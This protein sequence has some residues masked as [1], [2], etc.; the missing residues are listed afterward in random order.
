MSTDPIRVVVADDFPLMRAAL[1]EGWRRDP[2]IDVVGQASDGAEAMALV[3]SERPDVLVSDLD[4][5]VADGY[6]VLEQLRGSKTRVLIVTAKDSAEAMMEALARGACGYMTK[7]SSVADLCEAVV[8]VMRGD[9]PLAPHLSSAFVR[10][11]TR[12]H[13]RGGSC[14]GRPR[15]RRARVDAHG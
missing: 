6:E 1:V 7:H 5:P 2:R 15:A 3:H 9:T 13:R 11:L 8:S 12:E 14:A 10:G 4:M